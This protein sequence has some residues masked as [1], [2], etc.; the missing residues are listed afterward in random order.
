MEKFEKFEVKVESGR[1]TVTGAFFVDESFFETCLVVTNEICER[2]DST[3]TEDIARA[4]NKIG[5][6]NL[7]EILAACYFIGNKHGRLQ[8]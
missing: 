4:L 7:Q 6:K 8:G 2:H 1:K 3:I 5:P